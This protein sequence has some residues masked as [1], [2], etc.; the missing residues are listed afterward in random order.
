MDLN[1]F[2]NE[3]ELKYKKK[4]ISTTHGGFEV[5]VVT[6]T[7]QRHQHNDSYIYCT[8]TYTYIYDKVLNK[9]GALCSNICSGILR[10][11][12]KGGRHDLAVYPQCLPQNFDAIA[13]SQAEKFPKTCAGLQAGVPC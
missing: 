6:N 2:L 13:R 12:E 3:K 9:R 8:N 11:L 1:L 7:L 10:E 4:D 5:T